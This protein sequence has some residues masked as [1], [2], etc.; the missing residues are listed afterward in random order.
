MSAITP[1]GLLLS[2]A[3]RPV[4]I[5]YITAPNANRSDATSASRPS[6]RSGAM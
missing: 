4:A 1:A 5:S 2:N 3:R 6:S